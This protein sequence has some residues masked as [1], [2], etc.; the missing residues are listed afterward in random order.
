MSNIIRLTQ[1]DKTKVWVNMDRIDVMH[2]R[3]PE[4]AMLFFATTNEQK[5][6]YRVEVLESPHHIQG[7][8]R[9]ES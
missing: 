7:Q 9:N 5:Q 1:P 8:L 2:L 4:G 6:P 3:E